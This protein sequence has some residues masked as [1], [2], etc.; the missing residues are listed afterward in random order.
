MAAELDK[1]LLGHAVGRAYLHYLKWDYA[2]N[3]K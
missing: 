2:N 1:P 3:P